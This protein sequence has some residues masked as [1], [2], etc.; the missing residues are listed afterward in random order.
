[1]DIHL[2]ALD[3]GHGRVKLGVFEAGELT[4]TNRLAADGPFENV[5]GAVE[6]A[7][8]RLGGESAEV[9]AVVSNR[10]LGERVLEAAA[11]ATGHRPQVVGRDVDY[12]IAVATDEPAGTGADRVVN[13]A[14]AYEQ[15]KKAC[16]VVDAGTAVTV[17]FC[18]D[19]GTFQGGC[20][21]PGARLQAE[22]LHRAAP[23]LPLV[24]VAATDAAFGTDTESAINAGLVHGIRGLVRSAVEA[25]AMTLDAWPEVIAT[26]GDALALFDGWDLVHAVSPDLTLYGVA[27]AFAQHHIKHR[28]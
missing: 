20:I 19:D 14:A 21:A 13:V 11:R 12:P 7:W 15:L 8:R 2:L 5:A 26:G 6:E 1:M 28:T 24:T 25:H 17:D 22:A 9:A 4:Y 18:G 3:V 27:L 23:Q 16:V 10:E